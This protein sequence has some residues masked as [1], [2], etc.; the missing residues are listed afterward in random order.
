MDG[1]EN[2]AG[3]PLVV[4]MMLG[5]GTLAAKLDVPTLRNQGGERRGDGGC[6]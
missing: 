2:V 3:G 1:R 5:K 6:G 4:N